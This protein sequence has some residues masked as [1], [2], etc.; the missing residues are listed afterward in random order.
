MEQQRSFVLISYQV[1]PEGILQG[2]LAELL[3][4]NPGCLQAGISQDL[5]WKVP[6]VS[7]ALT[8]RGTHQ[9]APET[10]KFPFCTEIQE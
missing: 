10:P 2:L 5:R 6:A 4:A 1:T 7:A 3:P 8:A 9:S